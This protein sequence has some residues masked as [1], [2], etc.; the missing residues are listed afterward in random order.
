MAT[1]GTTVQV[2]PMPAAHCPRIT[3]VHAGHA[4]AARFA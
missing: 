3:A 2:G 1:Y 4:T